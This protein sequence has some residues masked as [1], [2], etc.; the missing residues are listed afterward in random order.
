MNDIHIYLKTGLILFTNIT[1]R[2]VRVYDDK[3][4]FHPRPMRI[5]LKQKIV[6]K[7]NFNENK[8]K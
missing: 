1:G 5:M 4:L 8:I 6:M 2:E 7:T 3:P